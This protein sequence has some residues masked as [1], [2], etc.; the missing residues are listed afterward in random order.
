MSPKSIFYYNMVLL[1]SQSLLKT[2]KAPFFSCSSLFCFFL[3]MVAIILPFFIAFASHEFWKK[4]ETYYEQPQ[5][6][7]RKELLVEVYSETETLVGSSII[8][9]PSIQFFSTIGDLNDFY[10][11][12]F[13]P[14]ILKSSKLDSNFDDYAEEYNFNLTM[15]TSGDNIKNIKILSFYDYQ[16]RKRIKMDLV[17]LALVDLDTPNGA[18]QVYIDGD[19]AFKQLKP[20]SPSSSIRDE[21][22]TSVLSLST[23][24]ENFLPKLSLRYAERNYTTQ[25]KY[26]S[27]VY[28][29]GQDFATIH[30]KVRIPTDQRF[31]Y[32]PKF[33]ELMKYA[34]IQYQS[35]L[36]PIGILFYSLAL[37]IFGNQILEADEENEMKIKY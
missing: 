9:T 20:L 19:L 36:I 27:S 34:W 37:F 2:Y 5:V 22:N 1:F 16:I 25:F 24:F 12:N 13:S 6:F 21:Y 33:L 3:F 23:G 15:Y 35:I 11:E 7:Y 30:M 32:A 26:L 18:S 17:G 8:K 29:R 4:R 28:P 10:F 14:M 31:E